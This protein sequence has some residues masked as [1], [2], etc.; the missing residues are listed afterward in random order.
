MAKLT[1]TAIADSLKGG[2]IPREF[3]LGYGLAFTVPDRAV[4]GVR[5]V[6]V[7]GM[8]G[9][10]D[11]DL[12]PR[13]RE[14]VDAFRVACRSVETRRR[15]GGEH[16]TEIKVDEIVNNPDEC[17][18]QITRMVRDKEHRVIEHPKAMRVVYHKEKGTINTEPL[19]PQTFR[20][21]RGL[22]DGIRDHFEKNATKVT[23]YKV[24]EAIRR[25][26]EHQGATLLKPSLYFAPVDSY[27]ILI[28]L[29]DVLE[30][31][32]SNSDAGMF[33]FPQVN[34]EYEKGM[35]EDAFTM[36]TGAALDEMLADVV[37]HQKS[38]QIRQ[39][40]L[41]NLFAKHANM[42]TTIERYKGLLNSELASVD[43]KRGLFMEALENL[44]TE[45]ME[46][47]A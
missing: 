29:R 25:T 5:L 26:L 9:L 18:Y 44:Y 40:K 36:N 13:K 47:A 6:R 39:D 8:S 14:P 19:D 3:L 46:S 28:A 43:E 35:I 15:N 1:S 38:G 4:S 16:V 37:N 27:E 42:Q 10:L 2:V 23:G 34:G 12:V 33:L 21:L 32:Y 30:G 20:L 11:P 31:L 45:K 22:A 17:V 24:R 7:W 41:D